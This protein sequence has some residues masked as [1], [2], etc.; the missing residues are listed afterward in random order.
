MFS[1][2]F[3]NDDSLISLSYNIEQTKINVRTKPIVK[4]S[5][6]DYALWNEGL[7]ADPAAM[8]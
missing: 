5:I 8:G 1:T 4:H 7:T 2:R 6:Y 3:N